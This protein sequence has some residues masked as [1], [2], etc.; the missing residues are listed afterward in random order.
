MEPDRTGFEGKLGAGKTANKNWFLKLNKQNKPEMISKAVME[1]RNHSKYELTKKIN[2][3]TNSLTFRSIQGGEHKYTGGVGDGEQD[4]GAVSTLV[5]QPSKMG[6]GEGGEVRDEGV[7][8]SLGWQQR[9]GVE[10]FHASTEVHSAAAI[11]GGKPV[12]GDSTK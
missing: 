4:G 1:N 12:L 2:T 9:A 6:V 8:N 7:V 11:Q 5:L 10:E 3:K